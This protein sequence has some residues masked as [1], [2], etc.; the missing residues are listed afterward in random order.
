[1]GPPAYAF[2]FPFLQKMKYHVQQTYTLWLN[3]LL[4]NQPIR[5]INGQKQL[6]NKTVCVL[7]NS[8]IILNFCSIFA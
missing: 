4:P 8:H 6:Y 3:F 7:Y 1:M 5:N 2:P